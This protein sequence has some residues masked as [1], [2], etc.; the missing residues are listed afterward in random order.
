MLLASSRL[1]ETTPKLCISLLLKWR[2]VA[3][4]TIR[5]GAHACVLEP[6]L[7]D[8]ETTEGS[9]MTA[10]DQ[11]TIDWRAHCTIACLILFLISSH[12]ALVA[13]SSSRRQ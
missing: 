5:A 7:L 9:M 12:L 3:I 1:Q 2:I 10:E 13:V 6:V 8:V 4:L 11:D